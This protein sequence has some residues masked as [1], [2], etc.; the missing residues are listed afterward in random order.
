M[1]DKKTRY[2]NGTY[3]EIR[4]I[5]GFNHHEVLFKGRARVDD[6]REVLRLVNNAKLRGA[7]S[8]MAHDD[9][10]KFLFGDD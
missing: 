6:D 3:V 9:N 4:L 7:F 8:D 5:D 1:T 2:L 10:R